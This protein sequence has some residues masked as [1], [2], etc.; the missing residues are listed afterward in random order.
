MIYA[1]SAEGTE[2]VKFGLAR[3]PKFRLNEL[4]VG[5]PLRLVLIASVGWHDQNE[6]LIHSVFEPELIRGEW[7]KRT[8][9]VNRFLELLTEELYRLAAEDAEQFRFIRCMSFLADEIDSG[10][11]G[12]YAANLHFGPE[13]YDPPVSEEVQCRMRFIRSLRGLPPEEREKRLRAAA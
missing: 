5:C 9:R 8:K 12:W 10:R 6:R 13:P 2:A 4:Q 1:I 3:N 7:F 11:C